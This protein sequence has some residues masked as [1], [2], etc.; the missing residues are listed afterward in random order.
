[1]ILVNIITE[2]Y[3]KLVNTI[4]KKHINL[5]NRNILK[6]DKFFDLFNYYGKRK[7]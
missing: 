3:I 1:M 2:K 4:T 5:M 6:F 7:M